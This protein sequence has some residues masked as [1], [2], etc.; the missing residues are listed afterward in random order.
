MRSVPTA[1]SMAP[2]LPFKYVGGDAAIDLVNTVDWTRRAPVNDRL[3]SYERLTDWAEGAAL[4]TPRLGDALRALAR[5]T[6]R[7]SERVLREAAALRWTL[8]RLFVAIAHHE[9]TPAPAVDEL[10]AALNVA[11]ARM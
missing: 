10:N 1:S 6:P 2:D 11:M 5:E 9:A 8:R 4:I 3:T 7:Q